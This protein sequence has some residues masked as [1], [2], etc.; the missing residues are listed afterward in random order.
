MKRELSAYFSSAIGYVFLA[1]FYIF[2]G[3]FFYGSSLYNGGTASLSGVFDL[4]FTVVL[5]LVPILTMRL[6]SED[7]RQK[8][9]QA[10]FTAPVRLSSITLGK[11]FSALIVYAISVCITLVFGMVISFYGAPDWAVIMGNLIGLFLLGSALIS[12]GMFISSLT[13]NQ[14]IAAVGGFSASLFILLVDPLAQ[15]VPVEF[16]S[17]F[18]SG[19]SF[20]AHYENFTVGILSL[21]DVVFFLS[22]IAIFVFLTVRVFEKKRWS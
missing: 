7:K 9:D 22:V 10:L 17:K 5:F 12:I 19:I 15:I 4:M 20:N 21:A 16:I 6:W 1:V 18:L 2:S 3:Y 13:E 11:Y 8:T 14:V